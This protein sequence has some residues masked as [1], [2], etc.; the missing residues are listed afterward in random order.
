MSGLLSRR[1]RKREIGEGGGRGGA[2]RSS[3]R[4]RTDRRKTVVPRSRGRKRGKE[5][6]DAVGYGNE[7]EKN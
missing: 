5:R 1:K 7:K 3:I 6:E 2:R 4:R